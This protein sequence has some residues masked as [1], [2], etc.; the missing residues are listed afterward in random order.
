MN[1]ISPIARFYASFI[2]TIYGMH[3]PTSSIKFTHKTFALYVA[4]IKYN[5]TVVGTHCAC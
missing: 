4:D 5:A 2:P 1:E 3:A